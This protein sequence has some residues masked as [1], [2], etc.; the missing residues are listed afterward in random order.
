MMLQEV[1]IASPLNIEGI[2]VYQKNMHLFE[3]HKQSLADD[4]S[5]Y[6]NADNMW[7]VIRSDASIPVTD[8]TNTNTVTINQVTGMVT[9]S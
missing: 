9:A 5:R 6:Q 1:A 4:I 3:E 2:Q 7:D 8:G